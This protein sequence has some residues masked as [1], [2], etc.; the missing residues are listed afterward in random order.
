MSGKY[1]IVEKEYENGDKVFTAYEVIEGF[2][3]I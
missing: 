2:Y 1:K 3:I